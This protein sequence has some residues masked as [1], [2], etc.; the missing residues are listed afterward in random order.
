MSQVILNFL[1]EK[2][3]DDNYAHANDI[4]VFKGDYRPLV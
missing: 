3:Y 2:I 4:R 1:T